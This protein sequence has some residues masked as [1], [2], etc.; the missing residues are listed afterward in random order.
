MCELL[1]ILDLDNMAYATDG[2]PTNKRESGHYYEV[3][4][5]HIYELTESAKN[6]LS[7]SCYAEVGPFEEEVG[8]LSLYCILAIH[9]Q[10]YIS[11]QN[12]G[13]LS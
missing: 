4:H 9:I 13:I 5:E 3:S 10:F 12:C 1:L 2:N 6:D 11:Y 7:C 8:L